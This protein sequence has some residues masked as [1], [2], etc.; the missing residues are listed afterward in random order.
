VLSVCIERSS[1]SDMLVTILPATSEVAI[2]S[3]PRGVTDGAVQAT[4]V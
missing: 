4:P 2:A 3:N 1:R